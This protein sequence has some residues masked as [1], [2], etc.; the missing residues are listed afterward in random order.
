MRPSP[1]FSAAVLVVLVAILGCNVISGPL[2]TADPSTDT[3]ST[4]A[5]TPETI[6][7]AVDS[8][9]QPTDLA[10]IY[11]TPYDPINL[12][13]TPDDSHQATAVIPVEGGT[14]TATVCYILARVE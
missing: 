2:T 5:V 1:R 9:I 14:L 3:S 11:D 13:T 6:P 8:S 12:T 10:W 4:T 7:D